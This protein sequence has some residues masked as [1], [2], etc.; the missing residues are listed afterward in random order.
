MSSGFHF[1][2]SERDAVFKYLS[3]NFVMESNEATLLQPC[4]ACALGK[5]ISEFGELLSD[6]IAGKVRS[7][8]LAQQTLR[9]SE[10]PDFRGYKRTRSLKRLLFLLK[11]NAWIPFASVV[12]CG[13]ATATPYSLSL[14]RNKFALRKNE[15]RV[16]LGTGIWVPYEACMVAH[17]VSFPPARIV[18][19]YYELELLKAHRAAITKLLEGDAKIKDLWFKAKKRGTHPTISPYALV[20][21]LR[22]FDKCQQLSVFVHGNQNIICFFV[23]VHFV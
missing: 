23:G 2:E 17:G 21:A 5:Y 22:Q 6:D 20:V 9:R 18:E 12:A 10:S 16:C 19:R 3:L 14:D 15:T 8:F 4:G 11:G 13:F 1:K 7:D